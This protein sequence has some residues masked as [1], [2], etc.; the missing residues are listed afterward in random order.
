MIASAIILIP[1]IKDIIQEKNQR[2][3]LE[4]SKHD[5]ERLQSETNYKQINYS[6]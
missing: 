5:Q 3:E 2:E 4:E 6:N 1:G